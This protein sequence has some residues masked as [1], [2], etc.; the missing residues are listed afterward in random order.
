MR[1]PV[2][3]LASKKGPEIQKFKITVLFHP[4]S[5]KKGFQLPQ[6]KI[7]VLFH[8][9]RQGLQLTKFKITAIAPFNEFCYEMFFFQISGG[10]GT[11]EY[12][13]HSERWAE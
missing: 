8:L 4:A 9:T 5:R 13:A 3:D 12:F 1:G 7:A 6:F 10:R 2:K 11:A